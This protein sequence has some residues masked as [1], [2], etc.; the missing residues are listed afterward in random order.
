SSKAVTISK[1]LQT[2]SLYIDDDENDNRNSTFN[3]YRSD[4]TIVAN[5]TFSDSK[6][7]NLL[8]DFN[9]YRTPERQSDLFSSKTR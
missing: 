6:T 8:T 4:N 5:V 9:A 3:D 2:E 1:D 7:A